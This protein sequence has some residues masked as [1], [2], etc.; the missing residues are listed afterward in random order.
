V[1]EVIKVNM[2]DLPV[3]KQDTPILDYCRK[4]IKDG[5]DPSTILEVYR[6]SIPDEPSMTVRG[7]G[8]GAKLA[9]NGECRFVPFVPLEGEKLKKLREYTPTIRVRRAE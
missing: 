3:S 8:Q 4:L 5:K 6:D 1:K 9:V 7:I 2:K